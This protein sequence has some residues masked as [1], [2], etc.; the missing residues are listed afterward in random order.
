MNVKQAKNISLV[1][2]LQQLGCDTPE[3]RGGEL[4]YFSPF[5]KEGDRSFQVHP[6]KNIWMDFGNLWRNFLN[7]SFF[8][9]ASILLFID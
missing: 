7:S 1:G 9:R 8:E 6:Q 2:I 5:R 3:V 4:W